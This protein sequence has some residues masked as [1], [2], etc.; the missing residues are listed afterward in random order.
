M[1]LKHNRNRLLLLFL[2]GTSTCLRINFY[3]PL[4]LLC[5]RAATSQ[6]PVGSVRLELGVPPSGMKLILGC[7]SVNVCQSPEQVWRMFSVV[8]KKAER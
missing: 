3:K 8:A 4:S 6:S 5:T 2:M 7:P 1:F